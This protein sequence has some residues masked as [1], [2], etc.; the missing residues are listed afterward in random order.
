MCAVEELRS[1]EKWEKVFYN[2][3]GTKENY[4][5]PKKLNKD[6]EYYNEVLRFMDN[7]IDDLRSNDIEQ[8]YIDIAKE[9]KGIF[10]NVLTKYYE[11]KIVEAYDIINNLIKEYKENHI[12]FSKLSKSF[13]F[14]Y[15]VI[16][17]KEWDEFIFFRARSGNIE[18]EDKRDSLKHTPFD[19]ISKIGS[20]RF[21]I[22]GQPCLYLGSTSYAC[23]IEMDKPSDKDFSAGCILLN[24]DYEILN[25]STDIRVFLGAVDALKQET[26]KQMMFKS[27]LLSQVTSFRIN[28]EK[29]NFKSEYIIS[30]LITLACKSNGIEGISY[31][32]K[33]VSSNVFG[34]DICMNLAL[35]IPY[36]HGQK[37]SC[38]MESE[39]KIGI[40]INYAYF[41]KLKR[42][43][44]C[45]SIEPFVYQNSPYPTNIGD[46][47]N[48]IP[49]TETHF[50]DFDKYL[51]QITW[52]QYKIKKK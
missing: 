15:Y 48:Q 21:S 9:Y 45:L 26:D 2:D 17:G 32:S 18:N 5:F 25:L 12:I 23:W 44:L 37:Y 33:R 27:Y 38:I 20:Y 11:G 4:R 35:F 43:P 29:R 3:K 28:E 36:E 6:N 49:Y 24:K 39:M 50:Y 10:E 1:M 34:H 13:S 47:E 19:M 30:Q 8:V 52:R 40:P 16:E 31:I 14:N 22:P 7:L 46:F 41:E 51:R 42:A